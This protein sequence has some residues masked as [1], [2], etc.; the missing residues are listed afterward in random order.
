MDLDVDEELLES[1]RGEGL[2]EVKRSLEDEPVMSVD[3]A[4]KLRVITVLIREM[5]VNL[6][7]V[8]VILHMRDDLRSMR[9]QFDEIMRS[10]VEELR[11]RIGG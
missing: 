4:E 6:P 10:M 3:E 11:K 1:L 8:E 5:G 9:A 2:I 7:G